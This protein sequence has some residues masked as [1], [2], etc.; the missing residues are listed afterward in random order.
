VCLPN[1]KIFKGALEHYDLDYNIAVVKIKGFLSDHHIA[2]GNSEME[3]KPYRDMV[4][5]I[6][7]IFKTGKLMFTDGIITRR[8]SKF[9]R[10][11]K[12]STCKISKLLR[13]AFVFMVELKSCIRK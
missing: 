9:C 10:E 5:A 11:L 1:G 12:I 3:V 4:V 2:V 8:K 13:Y 6:G 7:R